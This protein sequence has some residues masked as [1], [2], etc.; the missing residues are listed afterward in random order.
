MKKDGSII[1]EETSR[2][3]H[4]KKTKWSD[5]ISLGMDEEGPKNFIIVRYTGN[6][7]EVGGQRRL[8]NEKEKRV[9]S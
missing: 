9:K 1:R 8:E 2:K 3:V 7:V 6:E 5:K 4:L